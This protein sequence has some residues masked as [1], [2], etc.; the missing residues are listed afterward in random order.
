MSDLWQVSSTNKTFLHD[1]S[2]ILLKVVLNAINPNLNASRIVVNGYNK[3]TCGILLI[4]LRIGFRRNFL[5][6][7][8]SFRRKPNLNEILLLPG[9]NPASPPTAFCSTCWSRGMSYGKQRSC[10]SKS[11]LAHFHVSWL[12][13]FIF[14]P[15][16][17]Y[18]SLHQSFFYSF[19]NHLT[20][21]K[22]CYTRLQHNFALDPIISPFDFHF[23]T[24]SRDTNWMMTA[25]H[26]MM[27][28]T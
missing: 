6:V 21:R 22:W 23:Q 12:S 3:I 25:T 18:K 17:L 28:A 20:L 7:S 26:C 13:A 2:K 27:G 9:I 14:Y 24:W 11:G 19:V 5:S 15:K 4:S 8:P 10:R 16:P 1:T